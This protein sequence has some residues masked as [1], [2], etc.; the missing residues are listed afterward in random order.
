[1]TGNQKT[2]K[3][4]RAKDA[5]LTGMFAAVVAVCSQIAIP[6]PS[7]VPITLQT[8]AV[9]LCGFM[10]GGWRAVAALA[11]YV[12]MGGL[13][14]PVF[15]NFGGGF[16]YLLGRTGG[17]IFGFVPMAAVCGAASG[18]K[19]FFVRLALGIVGLLMCHTVGAVQYA[20]LTG[21]G[22]FPAAMLVSVPFLVKDIVSVVAACVVAD[23]VKSA[24]AARG[25][26]L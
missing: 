20:F 17:F 7:G 14:L 6:M 16:G 15:S 12:I 18:R 19:N 22:F 23:R 9:A 25:G 2:E 10:L 8:A 4:W 21:I 26:A 24:V 1:M 11:V 3:K 5:A 13:G